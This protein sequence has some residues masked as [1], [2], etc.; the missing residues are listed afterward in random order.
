[1]K[2][3][4]IGLPKHITRH[5]LAFA[6]VATLVTIVAT[7]GI[8]QSTAPSPISDAAFS[9]ATDFVFTEEF[10]DTIL[11]DAGATD[12]NWDTTAGELTLFEGVNGWYEADKTTLGQNNVDMQA[13]GQLVDNFDRSGSISASDTGGWANQILVLDSS[14]NPNIAWSVNDDIGGTTV[15][16]IYF[17]KWDGTKWTKADGSAGADMVSDSTRD[18]IQPAMVLDSSDNPMIVWLHEGCSLNFGDECILFK[19]WDPTASGGTGAWTAADG[20]NTGALSDYVVTIGDGYNWRPSL[21]IDSSDQPAIAWE[22]E[23]SGDGLGYILYLQYSNADSEWQTVNDDA[24]PGEVY[25]CYYALA[26]CGVTSDYSWRPSLE[27][28][29]SDEPCVAYVKN[30]ITNKGDVV[31]ACWDNGPDQRWESMNGF[32]GAQTVSTSGWGGSPD[33]QLDTLD[34]PHIVYYDNPNGGGGDEPDIK[35]VQWSTI[36]GAWV[37]ADG[38]TTGIE[39]ITSDITV[40]DRWATLALDSSDYP[41]IAWNYIDWSVTYRNTRLTRWNGT[42][43]VDQ[44]GVAGH[45]VVFGTDPIDTTVDGDTDWPTV[46]IDSSDWPAVAYFGDPDDDDDD[47]NTSDPNEDDAFFTR[48]YEPTPAPGTGKSISVDA[49]TDAIKSATLTAV[50]TLNGGTV[51]YKMRSKSTAAFE[52]VTPGTEH[53]FADPGSDLQWRADLVAASPPPVIESITIAYST[54]MPDT[55][56]ISGSDPGEQSVE[57]SKK[58]FG[59][60]EASAVILARK[61][62]MADPFAGAPLATRKKAPLLLTSTDKLDSQIA[63]EISRVLSSSGDTIY[64]LGGND[65]LSKK[66]ESDLAAIGFTTQVRLGGP[67]RRATA[68]EIAKEIYKDNPSTPKVFLVEDERLVDSFSISAQAA[69]L[70]PDDTADPILLTRRA[71]PTLDSFAADFIVEHP[72]VT[73]LEIIGGSEA[74]SD[75]METTLTGQFSQL[76]TITRLEGTDRFWTNSKVIEKYF[77][78]PD[79]IV[80]ASGLR[81]AIPGALSASS[82]VDPAQDTTYFAALLGGI[83]A[84]NNE[85][86]L[87]ITTQADVPIPVGNYITDNKASITRVCIVGNEE[88]VGQSVVDRINE[89]LQ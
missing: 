3:D 7:L 58:T 14:D 22:G 11:K 37:Y 26:S 50:E 30:H 28:N 34:N 63:T 33:L 89:L 55:E 64:L 8:Y 76:S 65:A 81:S 10:D 87:L 18:S 31:M 59:P 79:V 35:Y 53:F 60:G 41:V 74:I 9:A 38:T 12:A 86:P 68:E 13:F 54:S 25:G 66:V 84:A 48:W 40:D 15:D 47:V 1:M 61:D 42:S 23:Y 78:S 21:A 51:T 32:A 85:A 29:S 5:S 36:S 49:T 6:G 73:T 27:F 77:P 69:S 57:L 52:T 20:T 82:I 70:G 2:I 71:D 19:K 17:S 45:E 72:S 80:V 88:Q 44:N 4:K 39:S 67:H 75:S 24:T 83:F 43:W 16:T 46:V 56:R 62:L